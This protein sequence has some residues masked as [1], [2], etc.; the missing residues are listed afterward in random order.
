[1]EHVVWAWAESFQGGYHCSVRSFTEWEQCG[2]P[3][4]TGAILDHP[5]YFSR[6]MDKKV[7]DGIRRRSLPWGKARPEITLSFA[8]FVFLQPSHL[9]PTLCCCR[10][11][12]RR[13]GVH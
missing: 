2:P 1:M 7:E 9:P 6:Y 5:N 13:Q 3:H 8:L 11:T 4:G 10:L 12:R